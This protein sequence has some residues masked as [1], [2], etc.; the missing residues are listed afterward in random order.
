MN[1]RVHLLFSVFVFGLLAAAAL[2]QQSGPSAPLG[3]VARQARAL[4][5]QKAGKVITNDDLVAVDFRNGAVSSGKPAETTAADAAAKPDSDKSIAEVKKRDDEFRQR[6]LEQRKS[7]ELLQREFSVLQREYQL[8]TTE[9]YGDA[10]TRQSDP[11]VWSEK[12]KKFEADIA[13][14][15]KQIEQA[16]Q[17]GDDLK[18]QGRRAGV[19][20]RVF[21]D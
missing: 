10:S 13:A 19:P 18:E 6:Y 12:R 16:K 14:K 1:V 20:T 9:F 21:E 4:N 15:Q 3:D 2:A 17:A 5:T 8:Q 11:S 7:L